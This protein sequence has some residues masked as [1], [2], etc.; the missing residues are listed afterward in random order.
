MMDKNHQIVKEHRLRTYSHHLLFAIFLIMCS[1]T[2]NS[3]QLYSTF[4]TL[5]V[6]MSLPMVLARFPMT[7]IAGTTRYFLISTL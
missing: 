1:G 4:S 2:I 3:W 5:F 6:G 7:Y